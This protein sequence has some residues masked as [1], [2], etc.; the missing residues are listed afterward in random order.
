MLPDVRQLRMIKYIYEHFL[1]YYNKRET[2]TH[3]QHSVCLAL[4]VSRFDSSRDNCY[5]ESLEK[6]FLKS[7]PLGIC[8]YCISES[9]A[10][11]NSKMLNSAMYLTM[12][13]LLGRRD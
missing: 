10:K 13:R 12:I 2:F 5:Y 9:E 3:S 1:F 6:T 8:S 4:F 7:Q 11:A